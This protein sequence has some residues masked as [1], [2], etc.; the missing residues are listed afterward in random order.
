MLVFMFA[1][2]MSI[3]YV[4]GYFDLLVFISGPSILTFQ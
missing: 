3:P 1:F 4:L 2:T